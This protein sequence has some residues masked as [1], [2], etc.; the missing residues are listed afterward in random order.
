MLL[1]DGNKM[2][3]ILKMLLIKGIMTCFTFMKIYIGREDKKELL[4][5]FVKYL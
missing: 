2:C 1:S 3:E 4:F 5:L